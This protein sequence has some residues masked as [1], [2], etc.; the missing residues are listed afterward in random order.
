MALVEIVEVNTKEDW[1]RLR[2]LGLRYVS[3]EDIGEGR[4]R[5]DMFDDDRRAN[6]VIYCPTM[7]LPDALFWTD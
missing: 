6:I 5:V 1:N 4:S 3:Q 7:L 2:A